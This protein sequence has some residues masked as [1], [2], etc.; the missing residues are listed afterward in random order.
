MPPGGSAFTSRLSTL[1]GSTRSKCSPPSWRSQ[2]AATR[3]L[4]LEAGLKAWI[5]QFITYFD[6]ALAKPIQVDQNRKAAHRMS[7]AVRGGISSGVVYWAIG[8]ERL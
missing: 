1:P 8:D 4:H 3:Q 7:Q 2:A 6:P 5:E